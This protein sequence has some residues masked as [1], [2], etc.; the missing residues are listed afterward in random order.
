[1]RTCFACTL[2]LF[3]DLYSK[4]CGV[5]KLACRRCDTQLLYKELVLSLAR[6]VDARSVHSTQVKKFLQV[7]HCSGD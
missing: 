5:E 6:S 1:M 7:Y 2:P 3:L 4:F